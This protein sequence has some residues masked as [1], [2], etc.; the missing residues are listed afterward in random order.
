MSQ[1]LRK[2]GGWFLAVMTA[3]LVSANSVFAQ[4]TFAV[5]DILTDSGLEDKMKDGALAV[6]AVIGV[7]L[8]IWI[9]FLIVRKVQAYVGKS[10]RGA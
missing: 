1:C 8:L 10:F 4:T 9:A 5:D 2:C 3:V 7:A 6:G